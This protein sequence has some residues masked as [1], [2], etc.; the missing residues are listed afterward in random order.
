MPK[1]FQCA[2]CKKQ[3]LGGTYTLIKHF[4][5]CIKEIAPDKSIVYTS[6]KETKNTI[7]RIGK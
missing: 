1:L 2:N 6:G 7:K 4:E 3:M 5:K